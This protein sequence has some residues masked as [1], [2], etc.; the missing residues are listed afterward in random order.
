MVVLFIVFCFLCLVS[1]F[2]LFVF[3]LFVLSTI[4]C[5]YNNQCSVKHFKNMLSIQEYFAADPGKAECWEKA[6]LT[7]NQTETLEN[8]DM[9]L[10][11]D[12]SDTEMEMLLPENTVQIECKCIR[13]NLT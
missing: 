4:I 2:W 12:P 1:Y 5:E 13:L 11:H 7:Q 6:S 9:P 8:P 10:C 3:W